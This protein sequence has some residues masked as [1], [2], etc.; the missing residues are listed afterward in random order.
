MP[1]A[2]NTK[3]SRVAGIGDNQMNRALLVE[4]I[5]SNKREATPEEVLQQFEGGYAVVRQNANRVDAPKVMGDDGWGKDLATNTVTP[6]RGLT[7]EQQE[8]VDR[9]VKEMVARL[10][11]IYADARAMMAERAEDI[12]AAVQA[13][14]VKHEAVLKD[15]GQHDRRDEK[16][17]VEEVGKADEQDR[18]D[19]G[20]TALA[21]KGAKVE[22]ARPVKEEVV[23]KFEQ[24]AKKDVE[25]KA[26]QGVMGD[27]KAKAETVTQEEV[28]VKA[29]E[30]VKKEEDLCIKAENDA[31]NNTVI[32]DESLTNPADKL[33]LHEATERA[34]LAEMDEEVE[35]V[36]R[37]N[38]AKRL[39]AL[40]DRDKY[41][42]GDG[43]YKLLVSDWL[44]AGYLSMKDL[45]PRAEEVGERASPVG[46]GEE[47]YGLA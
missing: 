29:D 11:Q 14:T 23:I 16:L 3:P 42:G 32:K 9:H 6:V 19:G 39:A 28:E 24:D 30:D 7:K 43:R 38:R 25:F 4:L 15:W 31:P 37:E 45:E 47:W 34:T 20:A 41:L 22:V 33:R 35:A 27:I 2:S 1:A 36:L 8:V 10:P 21:G 18:E 44:L 12:K 17:M 26:E 5:T 46:P 13:V 40:A